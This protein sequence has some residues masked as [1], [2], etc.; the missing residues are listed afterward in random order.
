VCVFNDIRVVYGTCVY[1]C[2]VCVC[3]SSGIWLCVVRVCMYAYVCVYV[4]YVYIICIC[5]MMARCV[6]VFVYSVH[7][8]VYTCILC[9]CVCVCG[10]SGQG[11]PGWQ[12]PDFVKRCGKNGIFQDYNQYTR[13]AGMCVVC[14]ML[15]VCSMCVYM[16]YMVILI[17][18]SECSL[19]THTRTQG[20][21]KLVKCL[22]KVPNLTQFICHSVFYCDLS[23]TKTNAHTVLSPLIGVISPVFNT[24]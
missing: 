20:H 15:S 17:N 1:V 6:C 22:A 24:L 2:D 4:L 9:V 5:M 7:V 10:Y 11:F 12:T 23:V 18:K 8:C 21:P 3:A 14:C 16:A 19:C 13:S